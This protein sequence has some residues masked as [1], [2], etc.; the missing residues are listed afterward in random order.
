MSKKRINRDKDF[1]AVLKSKA[2]GSCRCLPCYEAEHSEEYQI[3]LQLKEWLEVKLEK[4]TS[5]L[6][7]LDLEE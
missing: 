5:R 1:D 4:I 3:D 2:D 6:E 7:I